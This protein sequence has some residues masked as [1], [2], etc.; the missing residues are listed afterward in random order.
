MKGK[1]NKSTF[2]IQK[3]DCP[4]EEQ[5]IRMKL[6]PISQVQHLDFDIPNRKLEVF[7]TA[8]SEEIHQAIRQLDLNDCPA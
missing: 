6:E 2:T 4:S 5:M 7:H 3:M 1:M 8:E